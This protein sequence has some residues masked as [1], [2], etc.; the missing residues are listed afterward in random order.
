[1]LT[2]FGTFNPAVGFD[3]NDSSYNMSPIQVLQAYADVC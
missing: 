1:M 2:E 3:P